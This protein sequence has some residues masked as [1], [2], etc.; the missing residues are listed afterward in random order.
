EIFPFSSPVQAR[1]ELLKNQFDLVICDL[2]MP[3]VSGIDILKS[4]GEKSPD[5]V[6]VMLT[7]FGTAE[8]AVEAMKLGAYDYLLKPIKVDE[9]RIIVRQA[10]E[11]RDLKRE[12]I[13]LKEQLQQ[14]LKFDEMI[15]NSR[16]MRGVFEMIK[17]VAATNSSVLITGESGTGK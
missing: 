16:A 8:T 14:D 5:T 12:N 10:L 1:Q 13:L 6:F 4:I 2:Q 17:K 11:A 3:E 7:A 15:G 9:L